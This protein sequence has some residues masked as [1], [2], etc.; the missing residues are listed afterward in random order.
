MVIIGGTSNLTTQQFDSIE[1]IDVTS[2]GISGTQIYFAPDSSKD[3][4]TLILP[5]IEERIVDTWTATTY[6]VEI[7][8]YINLV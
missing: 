6:T 3:S 8:A 7:I 1:N 5:N 2:D 4:A